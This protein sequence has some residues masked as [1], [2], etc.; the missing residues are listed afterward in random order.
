M[1]PHRTLTTTIGFNSRTRVGATGAD[2]DGHSPLLF[3]FTHP[4][5]CDTFDLI[6]SQ[7]ETGFNS[8]TRVGA[9]LVSC[10]I[11]TMR[12][13]SIH[14]PVW[15][16]LRG[17]E[18]NRESKGFNSRTRVGA[19]HALEAMAINAIV[20]IHAPVW[21]RLLAGAKLYEWMGFQFT[22]PCGC[23]K[24]FG[25]SGKLRRVSIHAPVWVRLLSINAATGHMPFQ[26]THPCGCDFTNHYPA[27]AGYCFNSRTRVGATPMDGAASR[28]NE[29]SI[30]APVWVRLM[31]NLEDNI[32]TAFQFTHPCG[33][34]PGRGPRAGKIP[35]FNSRTRVG[36]T[37]DIAD[38]DQV[39]TVSIHAPVW[40]RRPDEYGLS[41]KH[42]TKV[43][44]QP[45]A[46]TR[47][48]QA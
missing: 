38:F 27:N 26:F 46:R 19:T 14:A 11:A 43:L 33:C 42:A 48:G 44:R 29:V 3:Q 39:L 47:C 12:P 2:T 31:S 10:P 35:R 4:C 36:A 15:V 24:T 32:L 40:V 9:T 30:H 34:D 16:R 25:L 17:H 22:H 37:D 20:S 6:L 21:V 28:R 41:I 13:V 7:A 45:D 18:G 8:R 5:G 1:N 23:D